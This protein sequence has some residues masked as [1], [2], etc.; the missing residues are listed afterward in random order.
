MTYNVFSG[1]LNPAQ[2]LKISCKSFWKFLRKIPNKQTDG[3]TDRQT[4]KQRRKH[5]LLG[6]GN[7]EIIIERGSSDKS[8][9]KLTRIDLYNV[10]PP[11][12]TLRY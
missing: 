2:S 9:F 10:K 4:N 1:T 12:H 8:I 3:Q 7:K 5:M 6:G 11:Y